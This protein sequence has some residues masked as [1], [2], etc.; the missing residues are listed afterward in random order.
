MSDLNPFPWCRECTSW[1][2]PGHHL[3]TQTDD[4]AGQLRAKNAEIHELLLKL[5]AERERLK[6]VEDAL[7]REQELRDARESERDMALQAHRDARDLWKAAEGR[8]T[9]A[10]SKLDQCLRVVREYVSS[11]LADDPSQD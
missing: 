11:E 5:D 6:R 3:P 8:A 7:A 4:L 2:V 1:H 9:Q 10:E